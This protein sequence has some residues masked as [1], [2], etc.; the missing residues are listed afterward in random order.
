MLSVSL[1]VM[2]THYRKERGKPVLGLHLKL[3]LRIS[4][5]ENRAPRVGVSTH[6][7]F[8]VL[9]IYSALPG[10]VEEPWSQPPTDKG[11]WVQVP[12]VRRYPARDK[13]GCRDL[14][15]NAEQLADV[16]PS[17]ASCCYVHT[18]VRFQLWPATF[19]THR[20]HFSHYVQ[21]PVPTFT[22]D[23]GS[24]GSKIRLWDFNSI[25]GCCDANAPLFF[26]K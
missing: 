10:G 21:M 2:D 3:L 17:P 24:W 6:P 12:P 19:R 5:G 25:L 15:I 14:V 23:T 20:H 22:A 1:L 4:L 13:P 9:A 7:P 18:A 16:R 26:G 11:V 8:V